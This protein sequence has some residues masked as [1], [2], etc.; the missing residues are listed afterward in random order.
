MT[1]PAT[2]TPTTG[3][4]GAPGTATVLHAITAAEATAFLTAHGFTRARGR[5]WYDDGS[6]CARVAVVDAE[7]AC[8]AVYAFTRDRARLVLWQ[9]QLT[10][11][12][13]RVFAATVIAAIA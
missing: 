5:N 1:T 8:F 12:P 9:A 3:A 13:L 7:A 10:N 11:A 4:T 6:G 2:P